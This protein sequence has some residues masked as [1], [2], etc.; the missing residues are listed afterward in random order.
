MNRVQHVEK[1]WLEIPTFQHE[2][3]A[4]WRQTWQR[5][6]VAL[7]HLHMADALRGVHNAQVLVMR[8]QQIQGLHTEDNMF[9]N[10][11][12]NPEL[13]VRHIVFDLPLL[14]CRYQPVLL[15]LCTFFEKV[16]ACWPFSSWPATSTPVYRVGKSDG[17]EI[18]TPLTDMSC[19]TWL[20]FAQQRWRLIHFA[21]L[22]GCLG[23]DSMVPT[24]KP[25]KLNAHK[26]LDPRYFILH[27]RLRRLRMSRE[28]AGWSSGSS[29]SFLKE[30]VVD[31]VG[32]RT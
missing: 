12:N 18:Q 29:K 17:W 4:S 9:T 7:Y 23:K 22:A 31:L 16:S 21:V 6:S 11:P 5:I 19:S 1:T 14:L 13:S 3:P 8:C 15:Q 28:T 26:P 20:S 10:L 2:L 27:L 32:A 30:C 24:T 25:K